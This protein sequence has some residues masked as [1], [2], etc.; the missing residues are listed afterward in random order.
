MS[1]YPTPTTKCPAPKGNATRGH[2]EHLFLVLERSISLLDLSFSLHY[3]F[4][5]L[6]FHPLLLSHGASLNAATKCC[7]QRPRD[8]L[9]VTE[10]G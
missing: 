7:M 1:R 9:C 10:F 3:I 2:N 6:N 8:C 4:I 5:V